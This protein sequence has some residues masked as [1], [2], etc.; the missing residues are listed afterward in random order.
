MIKIQKIQNF[1][2]NW[3]H[4]TCFK[5]FSGTFLGVCILL[6]TVILCV[7][8]VSAGFIDHSTLNNDL[9]YVYTFSEGSG[10]TTIDSISGNNLTLYNTTAPIW[11]S[12]G[13]N[14]N[15]L[16]FNGNRTQN[17]SSILDVAVT[18]KDNRTLAAWIKDYD[19]SA[20]ANHRI[21]GWGRMASGQDGKG[22]SIGMSTS[23]AYPTWTLIGQGNGDFDSQEN[24]TQDTWN[25]IVLAFNGTDTQFWVNGTNVK[26]KS[27]VYQTFVG[28]KLDV[29]WFNSSAYM[30]NGSVD[31]IYIWNR[32]LTGS[33][34]SDLWSNGAGLFYDST[35]QENSIT[36]NSTTYE[37]T[38]EEFTL[39]LTYQGSDWAAVTAEF[40]YNNTSQG[41]AT[42]T[43]SGDTLIFTNSLNI[44]IYNAKVNTTFYWQISLTNVSGITKQNTTKN[45]QT[46]NQ[47]LLGGCGGSN[48]TIVLNFTATDEQTLLSISR[49]DFKGTFEYFIGDSGEKKN[50]SFSATNVAEKTICINVNETYK[51]DAI[52]EYSDND[53]DYVT[54]E[55]Y[56][57]SNVDTL[58]NVTQNITLYLLEE[59]NSTTF[60]L[61]VKDQ[62]QVNVQDAYI[63]TEKYYPQDNKYRIVQVAKTDG[64]GRSNGFFEINRA[65]YRFRIVYNGVTE[66]IT[67]RK[68]I[69]LE[70]TPYTL[71]FTIGEGVTTPW[72]DF[73]GLSNL[74]IDLYFN[75]SSNVTTFTYIDSSG[76]FTQGRLLVVELNQSGAEVVVCNTTS[77][78]SS[79]TLICDASGRTG[80]FYARAYITRTS[81]SLVSITSFIITL[82]KDIFYFEGLLLSFFILLTLVM[83]FLWSAVAAT[84][85]LI[86]GIIFLTLMGFMSPGMVFIWG[87]IIIGAIIILIIKE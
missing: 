74:E 62:N 52:I 46:V 72:I 23:G 11:T 87:I 36:Y 83:V 30:F 56:F 64:S 2:E 44:P 35:I 14:G 81:E 26:N 54:R 16:T 78:D 66:L 69:V 41:L 24:A 57:D 61:N 28:T 12:S 65:L 77:T 80:T 19:A 32:S 60:I 10:S 85:G 25:L 84:I 8:L 9:T 48:N 3:F 59:G 27:Y 5:Q 67:A 15:A 55:Y 45:N 76:S 4:Q 63:Y 50:A 42:K 40:F 39:N 73:R 31:E 47:I 21:V 75:S 49:F 43:G 6:V 29:G 53:T 38:Q 13:K 37:T 18:H 33:E 34:I 79:A 68:K 51:V 58:T 7:N 71:T 20:A 17:A 1:W 86:I 22:F 82:A 70:S